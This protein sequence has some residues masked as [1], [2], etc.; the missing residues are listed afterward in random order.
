MVLVWI[1]HEY[2][3]IHLVTG[4]IAEIVAFMRKDSLYQA[5]R[6]HLGNLRNIRASLGRPTAVFRIIHTR[7]TI[8]V[9]EFIQKQGSLGNVKPERLMNTQQ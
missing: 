8:T 2:A 9:Y 3:T 6:Y 1:F 7:E 4:M 5:R